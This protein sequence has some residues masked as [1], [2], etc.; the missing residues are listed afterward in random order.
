MVLWAV[1][2]LRFQRG[3]YK[4]SAWIASKTNHTH[5]LTLQSQLI[6]EALGDHQESIGLLGLLGMAQTLLRAQE[7]A[8]LRTR[9]SP[10]AKG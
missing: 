4:D 6:P 2:A 3:E 7:S 9:E 1:D 5:I 10:F 8:L